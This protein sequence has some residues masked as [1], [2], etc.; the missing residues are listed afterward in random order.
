MSLT[1]EPAAPDLGDGGLPAVR[2]RLDIA[3]DGSAFAG[4]ARQPGQR[5]V[6]GVVEDALAV[7]VREPV[8]LTVAGRTD[9]GVHA[10]GQVAHADLAADVDTAR[11]VRRLARF[12]P[13]DV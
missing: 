2:V 1:G 10:T 11:L 7:L 4:W 9:A 6:Q 5:T 8:Q 12:L 3:Y 13:P